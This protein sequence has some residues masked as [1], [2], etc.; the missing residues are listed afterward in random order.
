MEYRYPGFEGYWM[1]LSSNS[2]TGLKTQWIR[3]DQVSD[4]EQGFSWR[5]HQCALDNQIKP[6]T[7]NGSK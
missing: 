5:V 2:G 7:E 6:S 1:T 3:S 4:P